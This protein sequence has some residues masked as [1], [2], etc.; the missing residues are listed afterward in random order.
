MVRLL[1]VVLELLQR[2]LDYLEGKQ[3]ERDAV[4]QQAE[5]DLI[6]RD[7]AGWLQSHFGGVPTGEK[8]AETSGPTSPEAHP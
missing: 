1:T 6:A 7:P 5:R 4:K 2:L 8:P 3:Q